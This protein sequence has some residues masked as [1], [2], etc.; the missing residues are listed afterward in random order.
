MRKCWPHRYRHG[1]RCDSCCISSLHCWCMMPPGRNP[2]RHSASRL[3]HSGSYHQHTASRL[4]HSWSLSQHTASRLER[5]TIFSSA[6]RF[7]TGTFTIIWSTYRFSTHTHIHTHTYYLH[8]LMHV[9]PL[10]YLYL[11]LALS[12][13]P[14]YN[15]KT[16][17]QIR[18]KTA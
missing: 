7:S 16:N 4:E 5:F 15:I 3:E 13:D 10:R 8:T 12:N 14:Q 17:R 11:L 9:G 6:Y 1:N 2:R 18:N